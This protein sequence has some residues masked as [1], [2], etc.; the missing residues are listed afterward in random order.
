M[1]VKFATL[2]AAMANLDRARRV[3]GR[4]YMYRIVNS[5][6]YTAKGKGFH[7]ACFARIQKPIDLDRAS[8]V[9]GQC[10]AFLGYY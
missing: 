5:V 7:I 9:D 2:P 8:I 4:G 10:V 3:M 1:A 6:T